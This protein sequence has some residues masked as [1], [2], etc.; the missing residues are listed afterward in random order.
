MSCFFSGA[1]ACSGLLSGLSLMCC[2]HDP[3]CSDVERGSWRDDWSMQDLTL[4]VANS[5]IVH[6]WMDCWEELET[7]GGGGCCGR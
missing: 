1:V 2:G 4:S 5:R 7:V 6:N 3:Q